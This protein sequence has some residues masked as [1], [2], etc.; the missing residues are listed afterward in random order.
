MLSSYV[1]YFSMCKLKV[2]VLTKYLSYIKTHVRVL[3]T[4][5]GYFISSSY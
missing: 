4:T 2:Q 1:Y 3:E 5:K